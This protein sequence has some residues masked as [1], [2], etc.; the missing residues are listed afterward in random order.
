[1]G[2]PDRAPTDKQAAAANKTYALRLKR[3]RGR[4][5]AQTEGGVLGPNTAALALGLGGAVAAGN[6]D[7]AQT[8]KAVEM[9]GASSRDRALELMDKAERRELRK[10][11]R[12]RTE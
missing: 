8:A 6:A 4:I 5:G 1:L 9:L 11:K 7:E 10:Q 2:D 12:A 3:R